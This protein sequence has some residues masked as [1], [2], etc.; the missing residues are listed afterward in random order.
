MS[1]RYIGSAKNC[2]RSFI[3]LTLKGHGKFGGKL[4]PGFQFCLGKVLPISVNRA[5]RV[6]ISD[7]IGLFFLKGTLVQPKNLTGVSSCDT[8]GPWK[9]YGETDSWFPIQPREGS[10]NF[11]EPSEKGQ[12]LKFNG[13]AFS[14]RYIG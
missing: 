2:G 3:F 8:D 14:K 11:V 12:N 6:R 4:T 1:K 13:I 7:F 10:A 9:V 5:R